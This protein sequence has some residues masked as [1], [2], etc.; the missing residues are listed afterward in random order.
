MLA[1]EILALIET[2]GNIW[3]LTLQSMPEPKREK[4]AEGVADFLL[5]LQSLVKIPPPVA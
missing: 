1:T 5:Y 4:Y 3:L 2:F